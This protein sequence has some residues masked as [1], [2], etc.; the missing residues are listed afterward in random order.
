MFSKEK[1]SEKNDIFCIS[2]ILLMTGLIEDNCIL[3]F[4][5]AFG[6]LL[7]GSYIKYMKKIWSHTDI[8]LERRNILMSFR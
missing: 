6:L 1:S 3:I 2:Q 4:T 7:S 8:Y 5:S